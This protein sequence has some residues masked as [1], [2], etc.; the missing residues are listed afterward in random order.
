MRPVQTPGQ[1]P[2]VRQVWHV[3]QDP[4]AA[5]VNRLRRYPGAGPG[6]RFVGIDGRSGTGKSTIAGDVAAVLAPDPAPGESAPVLVI[7]G[8]D[9]YAG[10][11]ADTWDRWSPAQKAERVID[12]RRQRQVLESLRQHGSAAWHPFDWDAPDFDAESPPFSTV[13]TC[14]QVRPVVILEGAYSCRPELRD[15][16]ELTVLLQAPDEVRRRRL[17]TRE[18]E[19]DDVDWSARWTQ[20][21][22]HYFTHVMPPGNFDLVL[23]SG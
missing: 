5:L 13:P 4:G 16:L 8:D 18:G 6:P 22:E 20:A 2:Q 10:G 14:V 21:E 3:R 11:S 1:D 7:D 12:W 9:F 23:G 17:R 19:D 15:L